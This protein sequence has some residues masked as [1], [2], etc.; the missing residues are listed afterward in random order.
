MSCG[1]C[2]LFLLWV[3]ICSFVSVVCS[4][5]LLDIRLLLLFSVC[6]LSWC[7]FVACRWLLVVGGL[8][9]LCVLRFVIVVCCSWFVVWC[10]VR[11]VGC[12]LFVVC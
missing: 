4:L 11:G 12:L 5:F 9:S 1:I 10:V 8:S 6:S 2:L 3:V 7:C